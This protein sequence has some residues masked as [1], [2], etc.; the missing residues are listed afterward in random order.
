[1]ADF[2]GLCRLH[3]NRQVQKSSAHR[4]REIAQPRRHDVDSCVDPTPPI[5]YRGPHVTRSPMARFSRS[6]FVLLQAGLVAS[7]IFV[8]ASLPRPATAVSVGAASVTLSTPTPTATPRSLLIAIDNV[9]ASGSTQFSTDF[10]SFALGT[11]AENLTVSG[12][13]FTPDPPGTWEIG[14]S[15][16]IFQVPLQT[17]LGNVLYQPS[18]PGTLIITFAA[19]ISRFSCTFAEDQPPG[20]SSLTVQAYTGTTLVGSASQVT[21]TGNLFGEGAINLTSA[22]PFN[23]VRFSGNYAVGPTPTPTPHS[24]SGNLN[25]TGICCGSPGTGAALPLSSGGS[26]CSV[27]DQ[28]S[29]WAVALLMGV[30]FLMRFARDR[31]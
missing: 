10:D 7:C 31:R 5:P 3:H 14:Q 30:P 20:T 17:L 22:T 18:T 13:T 27:A 15:T 25:P 23:K 12:M 9:V 8:S 2:I 19:P 4:V 11:L 16:A 24:S 21:T 28:D 1:M 26:S 6:E 29:R